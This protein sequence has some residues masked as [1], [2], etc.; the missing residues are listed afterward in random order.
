[1]ES[2][3]LS[4]IQ[5]KPLLGFAGGAPPGKTC[6]GKRALA[7]VFEAAIRI[8]GASEAAFWRVEISRAAHSVYLKRDR[9]LGAPQGA[10]SKER[11]RPE[12]RSGAV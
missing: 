7:V 6:L 2:L 11:R 1:M 8:G 10:S 3:W 12:I 5:V 4:L 9:H